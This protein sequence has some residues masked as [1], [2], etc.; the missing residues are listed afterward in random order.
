MERRKIQFHLNIYR[1]FSPIVMNM[2]R[3]PLKWGLSPL[4]GISLDPIDL[5]SY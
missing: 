3:F 1:I 2:R 4:S 5:I